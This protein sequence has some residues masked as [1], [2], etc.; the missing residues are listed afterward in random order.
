ML[1][2][3]RHIIMYNKYYSS[4]VKGDDNYTGV[5]VLRILFIIIY[6]QSEPVI[7][8]VSSL[9]SLGQCILCYRRRKGFPDSFK[10][11]SWVLVETCIPAWHNRREREREREREFGGGSFFLHPVYAGVQD[12]CLKCNTNSRELPHVSLYMFVTTYL[13]LSLLLQFLR[14]LHTSCSSKNR[15][16]TCWMYTHT[17]THT[18][19]NTGHVHV[20]VCVQ[21]ISDMVYSCEGVR[22]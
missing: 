2:V 4:S 9:L 14:K 13:T 10:P 20:H 7:T 11:T 5:V 16:Y 22:N 15:M 19:Q 8:G 1:P 21:A 6:I 18:H 17:H 12:T 3:H